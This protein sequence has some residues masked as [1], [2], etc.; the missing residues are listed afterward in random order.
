MTDFKKL[1]GER[2]LQEM[3]DALEAAHQSFCK[4]R[5]LKILLILEKGALLNAEINQFLHLHQS[6]LK[7]SFEIMEMHN[8]IT[9]RALNE[10]QTKWEYKL[11]AEG[12]NALNV[13]YM[14]LNWQYSKQSKK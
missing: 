13:V 2:P 12:Q 11:T 4:S 10:K 3:L 14:L 9:K 5:E 7:K 1:I 6:E 8:L